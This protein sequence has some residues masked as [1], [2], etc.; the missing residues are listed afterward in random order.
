MKIFFVSTSYPE[1]DLDWKGRF[2]ERML[3]GLS[4]KNVDLYLWAPPGVIPGNVK[5]AASGE[6][7]IWLERLSREGGIAHKIRSGPLQAAVWG[8]GLLL[9]LRNVFR[10]FSETDVYHLNWLQNAL[11]VPNDGKPIL[12]SVLGSD[13][14][15]LRI[16]GMKSALKSVL[17]KRPSI[18][19][20]NNGWMVPVLEKYFGGVAEVREIKFGIDDTFYSLERTL[21][22]NPRIWIAVT[23]ITKD[24]IGPLFDWGK[25]CFGDKD[26][27]HLIG[28]LIEKI[29]LPSWIRYHKPANL[30]E[31]R[32]LWFKK[33]SGLITLSVHSEGLPQVV[34]EAM[35]SGL[36]VIASP[37]SSHREVVSHGGNGWIADNSD[38]FH[39]GIRFLSDSGE[40]LSAGL[41]ARSRVKKFCGTWNDAA[42]RYHNAYVELMQRSGK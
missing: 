20:P 14:S 13:L 31:I 32:D 17:K 7:K 23:R 36:P 30:N 24:K 4:K 6:E 27:L 33:A 11:A 2:I 34:L 8:A 19:A 40:N 18:L 28:P 9:R 37:L 39:D 3:T 38:S 41:N 21:N 22:T 15:L 1:D 35:A 5:Y 29:A 26:E 12:V 25:R 10:R 16:P 42:E